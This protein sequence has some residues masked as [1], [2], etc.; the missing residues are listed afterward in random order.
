MTKKWPP[1]SHFIFNFNL[2]FIQLWSNACHFFL[3]FHFPFWLS[4]PDCLYLCMSACLSVCQPLCLYVS[5]SVS[6]P[7]LSVFLPV[8]C[9]ITKSNC[10]SL[11]GNARPPGLMPGKKAIKVRQWGVFRAVQTSYRDKTG[12]W[13]SH[14]TLE[15]REMHTDRQRI[16]ND[17]LSA[18][19]LFKNL[20]WFVNF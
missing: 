8:F 19:L 6:I 16:Q 4:Q 13:W 2:Q 17:F 9:I 18:D 11:C 12:S 3:K 10:T 7:G 14:T 20:I 1:H 15:T 5:L